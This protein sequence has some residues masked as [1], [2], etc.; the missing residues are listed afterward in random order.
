[1][2]DETVIE[3]KVDEAD[4]IG[5]L[6][7]PNILCPKCNDMVPRAL[8]CLKCG[9]PLYMFREEEEGVDFETKPNDGSLER[10][11]TLTKDL[12]NSIS[13]KLWAVDQLRGGFVDEEHFNGLFSGYQ[14]RSVQ[15]M[16]QRKQLLAH[17]SRELASMARDLEPIERALKEAKVNLRE[18]EMRKSIGDLLDGEYGA[19]SPALRWEIQYRE[20]EVKRRRESMT[21]LEDLTKIIPIV[22]IQ[23]TKEKVEKAFQVMDGLLKEGVIGPETAINVKIS[24]E[25]TRVFLENFR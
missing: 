2:I 9:F 5:E 10:V 1:M 12:M 21:F 6:Q 7:E 3:N 25:E 8:Y 24:L 17:Y 18:L 20:S 19:K 23:E 13:L 22:E 15:C 11:H 4:A 14:V 16:G